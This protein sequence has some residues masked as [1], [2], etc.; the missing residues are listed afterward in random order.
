MLERYARDNADINVKLYAIANGAQTG[1]REPFWQ[2]TEE[3]GHKV[4]V[5]GPSEPRSDDM[6]RALQRMKRENK[7][8]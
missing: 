4:G 7:D 2:R 8:S 1:G 6:M 5:Y 3:L